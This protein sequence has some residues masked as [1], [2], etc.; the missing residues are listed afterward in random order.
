MKILK[1]MAIVA[2]AGYGASAIAMTADKVYDADDVIMEY[3]KLKGSVENA[4]KNKLLTDKAKKAN[5][6]WAQDRQAYL[7]RLMQKAK[8]ANTAEKQWELN[9]E[10]DEY[11]E[12]V[13]ADY[14]RAGGSAGAT[15]GEDKRF[16]DT[17][18]AIIAIR[19]A[20]PRLR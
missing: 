6:E 13:H 19:D 7:D 16:M 8:A 5:A 12:A 1:L 14:K 11:E 10:L 15:K 20:I 4:R 3:D 18:D 9:R 2:L 17:T